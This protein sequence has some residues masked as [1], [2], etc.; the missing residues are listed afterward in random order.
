MNLD[1]I[2]KEIDRV[3]TR[4]LNLL[5]E[6][7]ALVLEARRYK[8]QAEDPKREKALFG[9]L[10]ERATRLV[11]KA[12]IGKIFEAIV[13]KSKALQDTDHRL[14]GFQGKHGAYSE[15]AARAWDPETVP[16][17]TTS[18]ED[19]F[20]GVESGLFDYGVVP[21]EN[22]LGGSVD[23][24]N[25]LL[26]RSDLRIVGAVELPV[27]LCLLALPE[28]DHR[29]IRAAY[30]HPKALAQ[31]RLF[32]HR[33]RIEPIHFS[34]TAGAAKMLA[35]ERPRGA[36]AVASKACA[37]LYRLEILKENIED[38]DRNVTRFVVLSR[39]TQDLEGHK[40]SVVFSTE[41]KAGTLYRVLEIF[42]GQGINLTRIES[43][44]A[45]PGE[46]AFF[47]DFLGST[48][49]DK[50][51]SALEQARKVTSRFRLMG[52]YKEVRAS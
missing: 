15:L 20:E 44:P 4:L 29:E 47:L 22:T 36:A 13:S 12:F 28:T 49:E 7:M 52:C 46:Y 32:L 24:V 3:D 18:F 6:R 8:D 50:V 1:R 25:R 51:R 30:S 31:C 38:L 21:V 45:S 2:R 23:Q 27:H 11:D 48:E 40:C 19:V 14:V 17:P 35:E 5:N 34:D 42:A 33:N 9:L 10:E 16:I 41:H 39:Q 43:I 26:I 37:R